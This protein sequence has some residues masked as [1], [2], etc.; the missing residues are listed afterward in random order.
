MGLVAPDCH[1]PCVLS[2]CL[3]GLDVA[4]VESDAPLLR[5]DPSEEEMHSLT[6]ALDVD[7]LDRPTNRVRRSATTALQD[8]VR[9][10]IDQTDRLPSPPALFQKIVD[11]LKSD[12]WT[13]D[14]VEQLLSS[15]VAVTAEILKLANSALFGYAGNVKSVGRAVSLLGLDLI[16][17]LVL[18]NKLFLPH[19][20]LESWLDLEQLDRRCKSVAMGAHALALRDGASSEV[21]GTAYLAGM[22]NEVGLLVMARVPNIGAAMAAPLNNRTFVEVE[23]ALFGGDRFEVGCHLLELWGFHDDIVDG[24]SQLNSPKVLESIG[25]S[26][27]LH[28]SRTL[29]LEEGFDPIALAAPAGFNRELDDALKAVRDPRA[30]S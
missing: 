5:A 18:G 16:R 6:G 19:E 20:D 22:V 15:D 26:W 28:A 24:I 1:R 27:Y 10:L 7:E 23:R 9:S 8:P 29:V 25:I 21:S 4:A 2:V 30:D 11:M 13:T 3:F 17:T 14:G 12:R